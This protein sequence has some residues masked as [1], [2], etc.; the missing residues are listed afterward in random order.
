MP[1]WNIS[2]RHHL[3][4]KIRRSDSVLNLNLRG[5]LAGAHLDLLRGAAALAVLLGHIRL[6][7]FSPSSHLYYYYPD[8]AHEAVMV[9]FVLSGYLIG[10][11]ILRAVAQNSWSLM[12][13]A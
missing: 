8:V 3:P 11:S 13:Y 9:F 2:P 4:I 10:R 1:Y 5:T 6:H 7:F 12:D